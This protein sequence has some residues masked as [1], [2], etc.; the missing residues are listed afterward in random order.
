MN[1]SKACK[2]AKEK[3]KKLI[4]PKKEELTP[5][6]SFTIVNNFFN[7]SKN[8][9]ENNLLKELY[10]NRLHPPPIGIFSKALKFDSNLNF[11]ILSPVIINDKKIILGEGSFSIVQLYEDKKT[12]IKY[13]VKKM[14]SEKIEKIAKNK[15]LIN[16][17]V[18]IHGRINPEW[19]II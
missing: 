8:L 14:N 19:N 18:N 9:K 11:N 10:L 4:T 7:T 16:T 3:I 12:G 17:E 5:N 15:N 2:N 13:A 1:D 6:S